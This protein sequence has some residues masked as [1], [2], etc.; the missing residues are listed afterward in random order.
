MIIDGHAHVFPRLGSAAPELTELQLRFLQHHVQY[1]PQGFRRAA[2]NARLSR[3]PIAP[4]GDGLDDMP[5]AE[6]RIGRH[7]RLQFRLDGEE[8]Y[9]PWYRRHSTSWKPRRRR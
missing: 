8:Y 1:H 5:A 2:D 4:D 9:L 3:S 6:V 7:G